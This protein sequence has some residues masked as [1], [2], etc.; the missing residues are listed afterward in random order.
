MA[1]VKHNEA[2]NTLA[3]LCREHSMSI[4][5]FY[6]WRVKFGRIDASMVRRA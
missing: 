5:Q 1:N 3:E 6:K 4:A 2:G